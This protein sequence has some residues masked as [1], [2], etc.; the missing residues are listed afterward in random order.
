MNY[1]PGDLALTDFFMEKTVCE[2]F[3]GVGGFRLGLEAADPAWKTVW[4]NQWEPSRK[5]QDTYD[6]Y[7]AHFGHKKEYVNE[8]IASID[9]KIIPDHTLLVGGFPCQDY[10]VAH[11]GAKGIEGKKGVL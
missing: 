4:M 2:L 1:T 9:K 10:S 3:A 7:C 6:C 8:D 11:T 5:H